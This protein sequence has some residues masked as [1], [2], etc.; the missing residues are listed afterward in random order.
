MARSRA[1]ESHGLSAR[2]AWAAAIAVGR[3]TELVAARTV[4]GESAR[5][6]LRGIAESLRCTAAPELL[7]SMR[8]RVLQRQ[9]TVF[10]DFARDAAA[11]F[12][13][14]N[15]AS[16]AH[17]PLA[18]LIEAI[19]IIDD[20]QDE[21]PQCL[22][23][24]IGVDAALNV[25]SGA[26]AWSLELTAALPFAGASW[27]A[28]AAAIGRG[29]RE[30]AIGQLFETTVDGGFDEFWQ[31]VDRKTPPLVATA[32]ELGALAAGADPARAA[33]LTRLAIPLGR[34]LQIGD[35]CHD[36]LG[37]EATDWRTPALNLLMRFSLSGPR[38]DELA[39]LL[40]KSED[41]SSLRA[42]QILLLRD[43]ALGYAIHAQLATLHALAEVID[44]L[45]LPD[46]APFRESIERHRADA[47]QLLRS[48]G[49]SEESVQRVV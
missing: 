44:E 11:A 14:A 38:G 1:V 33:M 48:S 47:E 45:A 13:D 39:E 40:R 31:M 37:P 23:T 25:A 21:E 34:L 16:I 8:E 24:E 2:A 19:K 4:S 17:V 18:A 29:V 9:P 3:V 20:V 7:A 26:L 43:G 46:P 5:S 49:V 22:A 15:A 28:A 27:R 42:A 36:A 35:D 41:P 12:D 10:F 30:T 6:I 32:L